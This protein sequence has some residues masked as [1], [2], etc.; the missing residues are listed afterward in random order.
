MKKIKLLIFLSAPI[1]PIVSTL[2]S[3]TAEDKQDIKNDTTPNIS[4]KNQALNNIEVEFNEDETPANHQD[5]KIEIL[6]NDTLKRHTELELHGAS[7]EFFSIERTLVNSFLIE[8]ISLV[9]NYRAPIGKNYL[10]FQ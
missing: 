5:K 4:I 2:T 7:T 3:C 10:Q 8:K 6:L 1:L 9:V